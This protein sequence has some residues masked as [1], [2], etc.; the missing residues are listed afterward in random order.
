M[1]SWVCTRVGLCGLRVACQEL[2]IRA[3]QRWNEIDVMQKDA[4]MQSGCC[5]QAGCM[6]YSLATHP[7]VRAAAKAEIDAH[8]GAGTPTFASL[9]ALPYTFAVLK[10]C[11]R[12]VPAKSAIRWMYKGET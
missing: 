8:L 12:W 2:V 9:K 3:A 11:L 5:F 6:A 1:L 4:E 10:E 7:E